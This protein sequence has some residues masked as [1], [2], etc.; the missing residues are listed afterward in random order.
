MEETRGIPTYPYPSAK[1]NPIPGLRTRSAETHSRHGIP[2]QVNR[3]KIAIQE[4]K[5]WIDQ[6]VWTKNN[7]LTFQKERRVELGLYKVLNP[8]ERNVQSASHPDHERCVTVKLDLEESFVEKHL[9]KPRK[10]QPGIGLVKQPLKNKLHQA[11][12]VCRARVWKR[13][14]QC[15]RIRMFWSVP[16]KAPTLLNQFCASMSLTIPWPSWPI[17]SPQSQP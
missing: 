3:G 5:R 1:S 7:I 11:C 2:A 14:V 12:M 4:K 16:A 10:F 8:T 9:G 6:R 13:Y 15:L 17:L